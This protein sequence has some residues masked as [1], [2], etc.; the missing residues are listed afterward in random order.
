M[1]VDFIPKR[2]PDAKTWGEEPDD[3]WICLTDFCD[4]A[5]YFTPIAARL[6]AECRRLQGHSGA[7]LNSDIAT[8]LVDC[9]QNVPDAG[10]RD[11]QIDSSR[12]QK[13]T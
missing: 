11:G 13:E 10:R 3:D 5:V 8:W 7:H 12:P 6:Y 2:R 4:R 9:A 1:K